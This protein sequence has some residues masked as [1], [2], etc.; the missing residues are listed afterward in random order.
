MLWQ[1]TKVLMMTVLCSC[2]IVGTAYAAQRGKGATTPSLP[3]RAGA[4]S[5]G[6][7]L[8]PPPPPPE[9]GPEGACTGNKAA[10]LWLEYFKNVDPPPPPPECNNPKGECPE[11]SGSFASAVGAQQ[12]SKRGQSPTKV[13]PFANNHRTGCLTRVGESFVLRVQRAPGVFDRWVVMPSEKAPLAP[14][15]GS[16]VTMSGFEWTAA[17]STPGQTSK[18]YIVPTAIDTGVACTPDSQKA[19]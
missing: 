7:P 1:R 15:V 2:A 12:G 19:P 16:E 14:L 10:E 5:P 9:C 8:P 11:D 18:R 13:F 17:A 4:P 6:T 3:G